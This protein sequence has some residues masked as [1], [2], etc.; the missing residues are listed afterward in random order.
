M[1]D[2]RS[3]FATT[4]ARQILGEEEF[5]QRR[6]RENA[7][8][9][10]RAELADARLRVD[11]HLESMVRGITKQIWLDS[12]A[13]SRVVEE[14]VRA[15]MD[16]HK[17]EEAIQRAVT[18]EVE[19]ARAEIRRRVEEKV[20]QMTEYAIEG[21][22]GDGPRQLARKVASRVWASAFPEIKPRGTLHPRTST[23]TRSKKR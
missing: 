12:A 23:R 17:L 13:V 20:K 8:G 5:E 1:S 11:V 16:E 4:L 14:R 10:N 18:A 7:E 6:L 15:A 3:Y 9:L 22:V 19:R 2:P 21:A